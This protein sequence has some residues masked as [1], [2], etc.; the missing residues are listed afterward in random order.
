MTTKIY[1]EDVIKALKEHA[2]LT[3][4]YPLILS[5]EMHCDQ[6]TQKNLV[7]MLERVLGEMI[8]VL[9]D[10]YE[11]YDYYPSPETLQ[12]RIIIKGTGKLKS[13]YQ[14]DD[15]SE[16]SNNDEQVEEERAKTGPIRSGQKTFFRSVEDLTSLMGAIS[17]NLTK[18]GKR[19]VQIKY[20]D[21]EQRA[22]NLKNIE[23]DYSNQGEE[24]EE[25]DDAS[26]YCEDILPI[27]AY[28]KNVSNKVKE[29][30]LDIFK[31]RN[32]KNKSD[33][34]FFERKRPS[35][36]PNQTSNKPKLHVLHANQGDE[37]AFKQ[38]K[39]FST[40]VRI[41]HRGRTSLDRYEQPYQDQNIDKIKLELGLDSDETDIDVN[42]SSPHAPSIS[43][44]H[45]AH[46]SPEHG[47]GKQGVI[48]HNLKETTSQRKKRNIET[49]KPNSEK[50]S[51]PNI[52]KNATKITSF[53]TWQGIE[54]K[55]VAK[56]KGSVSRES[57][58]KRGSL[59]PVSCTP[60]RLPAS[61]DNSVMLK[62]K[63]V[64]K[65]IPE[66]NRLYAMIG[67]PMHL[68]DNRS[69][70]EI[71][72][73][74]EHKILRL[75]KLEHKS[76]V[77]F[78]KQFLSRIY[79]LGS[80]IDSSN[81]DPTTSWAAGS[82]IVALNFQ[83]N[84]EPML[85][86]YAKFIANGG[87]YS[88]YVLKPKYMR[89]DSIRYPEFLSYPADFKKPLK[90]LTIQI[91]S[92]QQIRPDDLVVREIIDPYIEVKIKG[93]EIDEQ[94]NSVYRTHTIK[95]NGF[96]PIWARNKD[97]CKFEFQIHA[98]D[99]CTLIMTAY[100]ED[101][102]SKDRLGWYAIEFKNI[103]TGYRVVPLMNSYL[104]HIKGSYVF[105]HITISDM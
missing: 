40:N 23:I 63:K 1:C 38:M 83:K 96:Y 95:D 54:E 65:T 9:P 10:D 11:D 39:T 88:G 71:S 100:H 89:H 51:Y 49:S 4:P 67:R 31:I 105:C 74:N 103:Q 80:R 29:L 42:P 33:L 84:D 98:P 30:D 28:M 19:G 101:V 8:H 76:I 59:K 37:H 20:P 99:F 81:Y 27:A 36:A 90:K 61:R 7:A 93:L 82:Q 52:G 12:G 55:F 35:A 46:S 43:V 2:F 77:D 53:P 15:G 17:Q 85:I 97:A 44:S 102:M 68:K 22:K 73:L 13:Q 45:S 16:G 58:R 87:V 75:Y 64:D 70:W 72:S 94:V 48:A 56:R 26:R 18:K 62:K 60:M 21:F 78:H 32:S 92:G 66:L 104:Q 6:K 34:N 24:E 3:S 41:S 47:N 86:N 14:A 50:L 57:D 5:F 79:P 69:V 25:D 91:I